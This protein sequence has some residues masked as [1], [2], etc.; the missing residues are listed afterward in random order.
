MGMHLSGR[1]PRMEYTRP[2]V[3]TGFWQMN[4]SYPRL[5]RPIQKLQSPCGMV[6]GGSRSLTKLSNSCGRRQMSLY[7]QSSISV[8]D[9]S[10]LKV[11]VDCAKSFQKTSYIAY[12]CVITSSV[13]GSQI[14]PSTTHVQG[15]LDALVTW[16]PLCYQNYHQVLLRYFLW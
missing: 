9:M 8:H 1:G 13:F 3:L 14:K 2:R 6:S 10:Y 11:V 7:L 16:C 12:G 5:A 15:I 4:H